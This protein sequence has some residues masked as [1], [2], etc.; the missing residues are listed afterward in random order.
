MDNKYLQLH[1]FQPEEFGPTPYR[2]IDWYPD[3]APELLTRLDVLR[4]IWGAPIRI[5]PAVQALGRRGGSNG[6]NQ[7]SDH[8]V[9]ARGR[10]EAVDCFPEGLMDGETAERLWQFAEMIGFGSLGIYPDW[11]P[12]PGVH[13]GIRAGWG[14]RQSMATWGGVGGEYTGILTA[15][16]KLEGE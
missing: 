16:D 8:N 13:L 15:I 3:M 4:G 12:Q 5:S 9:D 14:G 2:V 7:S 6:G 11:S 1:Y 10:V